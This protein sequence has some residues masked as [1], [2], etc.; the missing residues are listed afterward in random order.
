MGNADMLDGYH[1]NGL[2]T[3]LSNSNKGI[4]ITVGGTNKSISNINVNGA[5]TILGTSPQ[6]AAATEYNSIYVSSP[7][8]STNKPVKMLC[9]D[10][11]SNYWALS[12]IRSGDTDSAGF[13]VFFRNTEIARFTSDG[14]LSC[15]A[16]TA[17]ALTT[18]A[19][20]SINPVYF[21][22]GKPIACTMSTGRGNGILRSFS[23]GTYTSAN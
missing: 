5:D 21:S 7:S 17:T 16:S 20:N 3:A 1:A 9:F 23:R 13:G 6:I 10:W 14:N 12:N 18:S 11:Y 22:G 4:S 15:N 2:L 19:G 8:Y